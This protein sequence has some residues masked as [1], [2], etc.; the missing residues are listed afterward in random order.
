MWRQAMAAVVAL[1]VISACGKATTTSVAVPGSEASS[2]SA[3]DI[4]S[5]LATT[6]A[7]APSTTAPTTSLT[8]TTQMPTTTESP[9]IAERQVGQLGGETSQRATAT[10]ELPASVFEPVAPLRSGVV[11]NVQWEGL[12]T[13]C[14]IEDN[15]A[16]PHATAFEIEFYEDAGDG[17]PA[18]EPFSQHSV[19]IEEAGQTQLDQVASQPCATFTTES[20]WTF[21]EYEVVLD[22]GP[23]LQVDQQVWVVVRAVT[24]NFEIFWG[25]RSAS[26]AMPS[27]QLFNGVMKPVSTGGRVLG[28]TVAE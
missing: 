12:Y 24:P 26:S 8:T 9:A 2:S 4:G 25:W 19:A 23:E 15:E 3:G 21:Y 22:D 16:V 27:L 1:L 18:A 20:V 11:S 5:E 14:D 17:T 6:T 13:F 10:N 28:L 7:P